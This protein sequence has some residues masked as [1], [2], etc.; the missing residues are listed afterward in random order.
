MKYISTILLATLLFLQTGCGSDSNSSDT[1]DTNHTASFTVDNSLQPK[2]DLG[3]YG[4]E[5]MFGTEKIVGGWEDLAVWITFDKNGTFSRSGK[6]LSYVHAGVYGV[7]KNGT[8]LTMILPGS[9]IEA[10]VP[11][12]TVYTCL[13]AEAGCCFA[14]S[15]ISASAGN[16][17]CKTRPTYADYH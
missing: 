16:H 14:D 10:G 7:N 15:N 17:L 5:V 8:Q 2:N 13:S 4:D 9:W 3:Y 11:N 12:S 1:N 6:Q